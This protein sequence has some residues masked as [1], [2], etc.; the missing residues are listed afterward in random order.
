M[1]ASKDFLKHTTLRIDAHFRE[2]TTSFKVKLQSL[3]SELIKT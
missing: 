1:N 3:T 2:L